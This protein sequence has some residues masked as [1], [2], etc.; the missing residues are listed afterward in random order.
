MSCGTF[1]LLF[2]VEVGHAGNIGYGIA[3]L[4][5]ELEHSV[6]VV[7]E[8]FYGDVGL[9]AAQHGIDAVADGL[10]YLDDGAGEGAQFFA[11][12]GSQFGPASFLQFKGGLYFADVDSQGVV[13]PVRRVRSCGLRSEF[14]GWS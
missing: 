13:R 11:D 1:Y 6:Q 7:S 8:E 5:A 4:G 2:Y 14:R 3:N 10:P 12:F 9:C